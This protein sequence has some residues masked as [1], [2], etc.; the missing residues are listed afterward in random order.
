[1]PKSRKSRVNILVFPCGSEIGLEIHRAFDG[2]KGVTLVGGSS[3]ADHGRFVFQRYRE[4]LPDVDDVS[5]VPEL[6]KLISEEDIQFFFPAHDS[7]VLKCARH[8]QE[9]GCQV[10][11]SP[12]ETCSITRSKRKTYQRLQGSI[13]TPTVYSQANA[14][15]PVFLKPDAGQGSRGT[16]IARNRRELEFY[17]TNDPSLL[18]L[19]YLPGEEYTVDCFTDRKR[20]LLFVG[21]RRRNRILNGISVGTFNVR[22]GGFTEMAER[23]NEQLVLN[24]AWFFQV[25]RSANGVL[26]LMEVAP[27]I[28]GSSGLYR[29]MGV[30]LPALSYYNQLGLPLAIHCN[31]FDAEMDRAWSNRYRLKIDYKQVYIDFDDCLCINGKVNPTAVKFLIQAINQG[32]RTCL[33]SRHCE[34]PL[35]ARL[36]ELRVLDLFDEVRQIRDDCS[37]AEFVSGDS[38]FI[39]DSFAERQ[40]VARKRGIPVFA[41]DAIDA[42]LNE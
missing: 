38:I 15:F 1:M 21:P 25:K 36:K 32:K 10:I 24:G 22:D 33:L 23:I 37:K 34:G 30:N 28:G 40:D 35:A 9:L 12:F 8:E 39:D 31:Q 13:P 5:F 29:A 18:I 41:V 26:T 14:E 7:V 20:E 6:R 3:V 11:G 16:V 42:L 4:G 19:A 2:I 27:R 17:T